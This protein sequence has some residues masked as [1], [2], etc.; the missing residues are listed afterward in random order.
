MREGVGWVMLCWGGVTHPCI[1]PISH[2]FGGEIELFCLLSDPGSV[3]MLG[4]AYIL[5]YCTASLLQHVERSLK[6]TLLYCKNDGL[7]FQKI[8]ML[9]TLRI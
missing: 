1:S 8:Q 7:S 2:F 3:S 5:Q 4:Q 6:I 9:P